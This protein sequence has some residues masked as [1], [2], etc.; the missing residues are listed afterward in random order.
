MG[1]YFL[2]GRKSGLQCSGPVYSGQLVDATKVT[3]CYDPQQYLSSEWLLLSSY[4]GGTNVIIPDTVA[5]SLGFKKVAGMWYEANAYDQ[6]IAQ[7]E[8][9][10]QQ[11]KD[12]LF[13][14]WVGTVE[15]GAAAVTT[16][17]QGASGS[18]QNLTANRSANGLPVF[19]PVVRGRLSGTSSL[20]HNP[21][22][23]ARV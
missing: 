19:Y 13:Q 21:R 16:H 4:N 1:G 18:G 17:K 23:K 20:V 6:L 5:N 10:Q 2:F 12:M 11:Y 22:F 15:Q 8:Q 9:R 7:Y 3:S 14:V